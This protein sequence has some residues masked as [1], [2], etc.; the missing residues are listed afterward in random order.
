MHTQGLSRTFNPRPNSTSS[1]SPSNYSRPPAE[2]RFVPYQPSSDFQ[3]TLCELQRA[4][5]ECTYTV[6][7][8]QQKVWRQGEDI[9]QYYAQTQQILQ[10]YAQSF[11]MQGQAIEMQRQAIEMQRQAM[12]MLQNEH[13][14]LERRLHAFTKKD[15]DEMSTSSSETE[16]DSSVELNA[17]HA[18]I[19]V[20]NRFSTNHSDNFDSSHDT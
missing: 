2:Y 13:Q 6:E 3:K 7:M 5:A 14:A 10:S 8:L 20:P 16:R 9:K 19:L 18:P 11:E 12:E 1:Q 15:S 4:V 17:G